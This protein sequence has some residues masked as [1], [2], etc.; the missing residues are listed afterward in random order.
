KIFKPLITK[1]A[2]FA[3]IFAEET[4]FRSIVLED[5]KLEKIIS[6]TDIG[7]GLRAIKDL[8]TIY[9]YTN[10]LDEKSAFALSQEMSTILKGR[11]L[12]SAKTWSFSPQPVKPFITRDPSEVSIKEE[13]GL[14]NLA[15]KAAKGVDHRIR[16]VKVVYASRVQNIFTANNLG[17]T[18]SE[19]RASTIFFVHAIAVEGDIIQT[20]Y[21]PL[22]EARGFELLSN[23]KVEDI[24]L[25]A[26][27]RALNLLNA[28]PAPTGQ[29]C[30][31]LSSS[32]GGTM[33]HEAVGH[34]FEADLAQ[35]GLSVYS[36]K[37]NR[38]VAS[39]EISIVDDA[40]INAARGSFFYDDEG[41]PGQRAFLVENGV[42][43]SFMYDRLT[44][45]KDG[46][47]ST[48]NGRRESYRFSPIPRMTNTFIAPGRSDPE[49]IVR[50]VDNGLLVVK[51]GGGQVDTVNGNFVFDVS[52]GYLLEKGRAVDMVRGATL[53][54]NGPKVIRTIDMVGT[55]FGFGVGTCGKDGQS[56]PISDAQPTLR[57][58]QIVVGGTKV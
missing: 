10:E 9:S 13:K 4:V 47:K 40:T 51:M 26:A 14:L 5:N 11:S 44:A 57:I 55:D 24:A 49:D 56:V 22:A 43:K 25:K 17:E 20:G 16:Q 21:E 30:A 41:T 50:S 48:G 23:D 31:V 28:R 2:S 39:E 8:K 7:L 27:R 3:D 32:A 53:I 45:M 34:G 46:V 42:L 12:F 54:G 58:P 37:L 1:G 19:Q 33:I 18:T 29:M 35:E 36:G 38:K 15:N 52:E 6:G